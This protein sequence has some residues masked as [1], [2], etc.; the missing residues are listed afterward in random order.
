MKTK[1]IV[2]SALTVALLSA[3]S[4]AFADCK[5]FLQYLKNTNTAKVE[6][7]LQEAG[8]TSLMSLRMNEAMCT[9][10]E[11]RLINSG[12]ISVESLLQRGGVTA[13]MHAEIGS[14]RAR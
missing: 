1:K 2:M 10:V 12:K 7:L 14:A 4:L 9:D 8:V 5:N 13:V 6:S 3:S 11:Q